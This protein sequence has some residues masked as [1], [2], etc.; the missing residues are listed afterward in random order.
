MVSIRNSHL[1]HFRSAVSFPFETGFFK[2][3]EF[4]EALV[5]MPNLVLFSSLEIYLHFAFLHLCYDSLL[6]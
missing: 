2:Y 6:F 5:R 3:F 1:C 4:R